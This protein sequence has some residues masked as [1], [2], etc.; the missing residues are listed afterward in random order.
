MALMLSQSDDESQG[1]T[2]VIVIAD[3]GGL[4]LN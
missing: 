2:Q 1:C 4:T 3:I